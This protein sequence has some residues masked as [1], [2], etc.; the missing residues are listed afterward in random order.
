MGVRVLV[1]EDDADIADA[2]ADLLVDEGYDV[3]HARDGIEALDLL[4]R[5]PLL[6]AVILLDLMMPRLDGGGFRQR[7]LSDS[8]IRGIPVV[9]VSADRSALEKASAMA[10][11]GCLQKPLDPDAL[12]RLVA[13]ISGSPAGRPH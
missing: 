13:G 2:I 3:L 12:L 8:R 9:V 4:E 11:A 7:Q 1:V 6:P 10:A 5:A